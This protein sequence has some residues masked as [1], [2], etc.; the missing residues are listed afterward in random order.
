M[1][2][3]SAVLDQSTDAADGGSKVMLLLG[4]GALGTL[5]SLGV[6]LS[7]LFG[8]GHS[9]FNTTS[10]L[11]WGFPVAVYVYFVLAST[12]LTLIAAL[13]MV[14]KVKSFLPVA[15]RCVW[16]ALATL[17][18]GLTTL[19]MEVGDPIKMIWALPFSFQFSSAMWWMGIFYAADLV[20]L[21]FKFHRMTSGDWDSGASKGLGIASF[22]AVILAGT[23]LGLAFGMMAMRPM[24]FGGSVPVY[25]LV[26]AVV[27]AMA[28]LIIALVVAY[29]ADKDAMPAPIRGLIDGPL[30]VVFTALL[31]FVIVTIV[32]RTITGLWTNAEGMEAFSWITSSPTFHIGLWICLILPFIV[33]LLPEMRAKPGVLGLAALLV[34]V[35]LFI[36]RYEFIVGGQVVPLFQGTR[37]PDF[38]PYTPSM[39]EVMMLVYAVS[40]TLLIYGIGAK[41]LRL[42][43]TPQR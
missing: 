37:Y 8:E 11:V 35:G 40:V 5:V 6:I 39:P 25:F 32:A 41:A 14:F 15:K 26:T 27:T 19:L 2:H 1:S 43:D 28:F 30:P 36:N 16:L 4:A 33:L 20:F 18:A 10:T 7:A 38:V 13:G 31:G 17:F 23:C 29:G 34:A 24:W 21:A 12:G 3:Q 42:G 9:A 22:V